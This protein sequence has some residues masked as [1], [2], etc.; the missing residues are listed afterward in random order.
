MQLHEAIALIRH[1]NREF[2]FTQPSKWADLG[3]GTG[4]FTRALA[5][6]QPSGSTIYAV[7]TNQSS[8]AVI[9]NYNQVD[10]QKIGQD[11]VRDEWPFETLDGI[12]MAN[13]LHYV[14]D[15]LAFIEKAKFSLKK[16]GS[17]LVVEYDTDT[18]N[19]WVPY[20]VSYNSLRQ[21]FAKSGYTAIEKMHEMPS[22]Y[23]RANIY[24]TSIKR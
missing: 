11:F 15:K 19:P 18:A 9:T 23:G 5:S 2:E 14:K 1:S 22:I 24:S 17:F 21:L 13:S 10:I 12:L 20:P 8:L 16:S 6:F 7:D 4:L 3:C